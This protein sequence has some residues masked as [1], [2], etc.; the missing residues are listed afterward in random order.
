VSIQ[1]Y[2]GDN[3]VFKSDEFTKDLNHQNQT[4]CFSAVG[5]HHQNGIAERAIR[6]IS[7]SARAMILHAAIHWPEETMMDLWPIAMDYAVYLW[8]RVPCKDSRIVP[9]EI[10]C[11]CKRDKKILRS[12]HVWGCPSYVLDPKIQDG[13]KI[14]RWQPK[15]R[16]G[17]FL[18]FSKRHASTVRLIRN[19]K[20]GSISPQFHVVFDDAF[21]TVPSRMQEDNIDP[22]EWER[23]LTFSRLLSI[24]VEDKAPDLHN[25]WLS[26]EELQI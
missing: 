22:A 2:R 19:L 14:L 25:N 7:E 4:I 12:S 21:T 17:Q 20:T 15:S 11:G 1:N 18:G 6:T 5:A 13:K 16:R 26:D 8:N 10:L 23:L 9:L 3:G 24:D